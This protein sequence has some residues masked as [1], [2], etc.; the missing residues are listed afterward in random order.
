MV[1]KSDFHKEN[2][3][4]NDFT[5]DHDSASEGVFKKRCSELQRVAVSEIRKRIPACRACGVCVTWPW[6]RDRRCPHD[7]FLSRNKLKSFSGDDNSALERVTL[8]IKA[9]ETVRLITKN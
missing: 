1:N 8:K 5:S 9:T 6:Q 3:K 4:R 7:F 2:G